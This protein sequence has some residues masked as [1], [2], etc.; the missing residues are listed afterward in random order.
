MA[1]GYCQTERHC[2]DSQAGVIWSAILGC[3]VNSRLLERAHRGRKANTKSPVLIRL[4]CNESRN[5]DFHSSAA[6]E[7]LIC[8]ILQ[9]I[10]K[11][12]KSMGKSPF[13]T[14]VMYQS[15][16]IHLKTD[17]S[18]V[19]WLSV[20]SRMNSDYLARKQYARFWE[21]TFE[22]HLHNSGSPHFWLLFWF[23]FSYIMSP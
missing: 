5:N 8:Y 18:K 4:A 20:H 23:F 6:N 13:W 1:T 12:K 16:V 19:N 21:N 9:I 2:E 14:Y 15:T 17:L 11:K 22:C 7:H 10:I 3:P